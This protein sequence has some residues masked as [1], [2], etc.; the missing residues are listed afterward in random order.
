MLRPSIL[1]SLLRVRR[2]NQGHGA[3]TLRL[4]EHGSVFHI[5]G[6]SH[7]ESNCLG[8][9]MDV[10]EE[11]E[12]LLYEG[13]YGQ[14]LYV[15]AVPGFEQDEGG[16]AEKLGLYSLVQSLDWLDMDGD[17]PQ[18]LG[19]VIDLPRYLAFAATEIAIGHWD[20]Y[21]WTRNNFYLYQPT[22]ES[23]WTFMPWGKGFA[24]TWRRWAWTMPA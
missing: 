11:D 6:T 15:D 24:P 21:A 9:L 10:E 8:L 4:F 7:I 22:T 2:H 19:E 20:G 1:P 13:E 16:D 3:P 12:G 23:R 14:D 18:Q 17:V 5:E